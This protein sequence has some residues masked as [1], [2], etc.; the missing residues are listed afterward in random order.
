MVQAEETNEAT[1]SKPLPERC[2]LDDL[3][4]SS[5][6]AALLGLASVSASECRVDIC[7][8]AGVPFRGR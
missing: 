4:S 7:R 2:R 5:S 3:A 1:M 6:A 8:F